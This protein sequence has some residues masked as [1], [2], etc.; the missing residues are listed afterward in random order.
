MKTPFARLHFLGLK[1]SW[2]IQQCQF[3][4]FY[5][6]YIKA[7][8][9][10]GFSRLYRGRRFERINRSILYKTQNLIWTLLKHIIYTFFSMTDASECFYV[11]EFVNEKAE[12]GST[13]AEVVSWSWTTQSSKPDSHRVGDIV[14]CF[15]PNSTNIRKVL[16]GKER[17][18]P[19]SRKWQGP[20]DARILYVTGERPSML[21]EW[22][23]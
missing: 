4:L 7:L 19:N 10:W 16:L 2:D 22:R 12:D 18:I 5:V 21:C 13:A 23:W 11:V 9:I 15:W 8:F 3:Y 14:P 20:F 1:C 6:P 17:P